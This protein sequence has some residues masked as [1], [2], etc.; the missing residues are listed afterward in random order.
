M[1]TK[2]SLV[3]RSQRRARRGAEISR[4][5]LFL[6]LLRESP[7]PEQ[8]FFEESSPQRQAELE[9]EFFNSVCLSD[10]MFKTTANHCLDG[11]N[12]ACLSYIQ[13]IECRAI[14]DVAVSSGI[15]TVE[16][17]DFLTHSGVRFSMTATD[18]CIYSS[19]QSFRFARSFQ[20]FLRKRARSFLFRCL[21]KM[22]SSS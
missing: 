8:V 5:I 6:K 7:T 16:W 19:L 17:F 11:V 15:A 22:D 13:G 18:L 10:G 3:Q 20:P 9:R 21:E 4:R 2:A 12:R 1:T 14:L